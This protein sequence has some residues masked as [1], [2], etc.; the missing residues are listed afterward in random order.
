MILYGP[1]LVGKGLE[2]C[3]FN[4]IIQLS[5]FGKIRP[6]GLIALIYPGQMVG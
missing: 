1:L 6:F 4:F 5:Q 3:F 2:P